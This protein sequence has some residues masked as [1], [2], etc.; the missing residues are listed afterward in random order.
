MGVT[1]EQVTLDQLIRLNVFTAI[2]VPFDHLLPTGIDRY[3][4][5]IAPIGSS[6]LT[7]TSTSIPSSSHDHPNTSQTME[8]PDL[9]FALPQ[10][11]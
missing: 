7:L 9:E 5:S 6:D 11:G 1:F 3:F 4:R 10:L 8:L 2:L